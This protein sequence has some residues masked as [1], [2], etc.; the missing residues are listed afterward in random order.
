MPALSCK[1]R[2]AAET[3]AQK[4]KNSCYSAFYRKCVN[5]GLR[6]FA[7]GFLASK[8]IKA[9]Q[10]RE[11]KEE[12]LMS[13]TPGQEKQS[14][15]TQCRE[16]PQCL[17]AGA[18]AEKRP[19]LPATSHLGPWTMYWKLEG[20]GVYRSCICLPGGRTVTALARTGVQLVSEQRQ[21]NC[22]MLSRSSSP[23]L[24]L[25]VGWNSFKKYLLREFPL[26]RSWNKTD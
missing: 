1:G 11:Q 6:L 16:N 20:R 10:G 21:D 14:K 8:L 25:L 3:M 12:T 9:L 17:A 24:Q 4:A 26:W 5:S 2:I 13:T 23:G 19:C 22:F 18:S 7:V 15:E